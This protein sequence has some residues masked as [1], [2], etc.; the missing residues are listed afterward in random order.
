MLNAIK[1][2]RTSRRRVCESGAALIEYALLFS[3]IAIGTITA[4]TLLGSQTGGSIDGS[5]T[6]IS[7]AFDNAG[8]P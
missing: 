5:A 2:L 8:I 4:M 7:V 3:L 6:E 1:N